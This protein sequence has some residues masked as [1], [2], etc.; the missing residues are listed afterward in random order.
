M[1]VASYGLTALTAGIYAVRTRS[2]RTGVALS[3]ILAVL[4]SGLIYWYSFHPFPAGPRA[5]VAWL[6]FVA[7]AGTIFL[8]C[9]L[10][11]AR[12]AVLD[13]VGDSDRRL[14]AET[15]S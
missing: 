11:I 15:N 1:L 6:F 9:F 8:Y 2:L 5:V 3:T 12:P 4:G 14:T 7:V 13:R 10:R